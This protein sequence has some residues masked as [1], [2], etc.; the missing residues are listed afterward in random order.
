LP[1]ITMN[2]SPQRPETAAAH[3]P[4][5]APFRTDLAG[6]RGVAVLLV[7]LYHVFV[8]RVSGG[9]DVFL[10][11]SAFF[12]TGGWVRSVQQGRPRTV[13]ASWIKRLRGLLPS[14]VLVIVAVVLSMLVLLPATRWRELLDQ[15]WACLTY[16]QNRHLAATAVDYYAADHSV[17]SPLQHF[18][19]LSL[20]GQIFLLWPLLLAGGWWLA[21]RGRSVQAAR[22]VYPRVMTVLF[23]AIGVASLAYSI[24]FTAHAQSQ[25]YFSLPARVWEFALGSVLALVAPR[26]TGVPAWLAR[27]LGWAGMI[28]LLTCGLV[29]R[30]EGQFP[31]WAALWPTLAAAAIVVA[32]SGAGSVAGSLAGVTNAADVGWWLSRR[33]ATWLGEVSYPL[34][35]WHWPVLVT[36]LAVLRT[37]APAPWQGALILLASLA[38]A[39]ATHR[40]IERPVAGWAQARSARAAAGAPSLHRAARAPRRLRAHARPL[41]V[42][43][44][45]LLAAAPVAAVQEV[46]VG[47]ERAVAA[48]PAR[49]NPGAESLRPG[50]IDAADPTAPALPLPT[51]VK[52]D[53]ANPG[54]DCAGEW[55][56]GTQQLPN[57][58]EGGDPDSPVTVVMVG[59][60]HAQQWTPALDVA[61]REQGWHWILVNIPG[62]RYGSDEEAAEH[63]GCEDFTP[64]AQRYVLDRAEDVDA[65]LTVATKTAFGAA[66][67]DATPGDEEVVPAGY[68]ESVTPWLRAGL[69]V[70]GIRDTPRFG[71]DPAECGT[72]RHLRDED[73]SH[74]LADLMNVQDPLQEL[75]SG[76]DKLEG[77]SSFDMS[78]VVCPD[79]QCSPVVGNVRVWMDNSH[80]TA[81]FSATTGRIFERKLLRSL[82]WCPDSPLVGTAT[83]GSGMR[84]TPPAL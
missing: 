39:W 70:V 48:Q 15:A 1:V 5:A 74:E 37:P 78:R 26:L 67:P 3:A 11:M 80:V 12:L 17:A 56:T 29:L 33:P 71:D 57:C 66:D 49:D 19:S 10:L 7:A 2:N 27:V 81:R 52:D 34:Y 68:R 45:C 41:V 24:W 8:G 20:Q 76:P 44:C 51:Q 23:G 79:G 65:V 4:S 30:V 59:D 40:F 32:G 43:L 61:A 58:Q 13:V 16:T 35:L 60:S 69:P 82:G 28:A 22:A 18:W 25:A 47:K 46:L 6:L 77:F 9:V 31:G 54:Q 63:A 83:G 21:R 36:T 84:C 50:Y 53:W 64:A 14:A 42:V 75:T 62:C 38:L 55:A 72:T 73:C